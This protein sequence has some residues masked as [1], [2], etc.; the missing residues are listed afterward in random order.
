[1]SD[2]RSIK[3]EAAQAVA[4]AQANRPWAEPVPLR[5][6]ADL[7]GFPVEALPDWLA[8]YVAAEA[9]AT[10]T[11]PDLPGM[12][13]LATLATAAGGLARIQVRPGWQE[14]LNLF[15]VVALPPGSRKTAVFADVTRPLVRLDHDEL[16]RMRP[17]W[18]RP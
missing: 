17:S 5:L 2:I 3:D 14:P 15:V 11:P 7:P 13:V 6:A 8:A 9:T 4:E 1:M 16:A 12:L 18:W 10:Q